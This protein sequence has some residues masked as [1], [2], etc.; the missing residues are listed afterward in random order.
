MIT[1]SKNASTL[2]RLSNKLYKLF[3]SVRL[4]WIQT[5]ALLTLPICYKCSFLLVFASISALKILS[6]VVGLPDRCE[7]ERSKLLHLN[8][9]NHIWHLGTSSASS[10]VTTLV[11]LEK[12]TMSDMYLFWYLAGHFT[13]DCK[14]I[15][16]V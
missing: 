14:K 6:K 13:T 11:K 2:R 4:C 12:H 3:S 8:L 15:I 5:P 16:K 10:C 9:E 7:S 1:R